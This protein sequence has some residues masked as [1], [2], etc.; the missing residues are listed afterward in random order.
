MTPP[1]VVVQGRDDPMSARMAWNQASMSTFVTA[2]STSN[3]CKCTK[4]ELFM[5]SSLGTFLHDIIICMMDKVE[6]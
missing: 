4:C 2:T 6:A 3:L 1:D 5:T